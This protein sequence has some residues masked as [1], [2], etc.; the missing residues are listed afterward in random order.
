VS[1]GSAASVSDGYKNSPGRHGLGF[2]GTTVHSSE[3]AVEV[4]FS[5]VR[6]VVISGASDGGASRRVT[7][8][9]APLGTSDGDAPET[10]ER[11]RRTSGPV[12]TVV[13]RGPVGFGG[14]G[15]ERARRRWIWEACTRRRILKARV[16][17]R[18]FGGVRP[19][20]AP[21]GIP[22]PTAT[23]TFPRRERL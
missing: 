11:Q 10:D 1:F 6:A 20:V 18:L 8:G 12:A 23:P 17:R 16:R 22:P 4:V 5:S 7:D 21:A 9:G 19:G 14:G 2:S 15:L 3:R 13:A